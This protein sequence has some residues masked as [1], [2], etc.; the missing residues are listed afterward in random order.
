MRG[1]GNLGVDIRRLE[2]GNFIFLIV[3]CCWCPLISYTL[4]TRIKRVH[5]NIINY[6]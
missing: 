1:T 6:L 2:R 3:E 4:R 5:T